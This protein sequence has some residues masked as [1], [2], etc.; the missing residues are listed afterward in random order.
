MRLEIEVTA[1]AG[2]DFPNTVI[3][4]VNR[5]DSVYVSVAGEYGHLIVEEIEVMEED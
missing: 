1:G 2:D 5:G 4:A 3:E